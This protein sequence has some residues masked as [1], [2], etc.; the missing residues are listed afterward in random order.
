MIFL[1]GSLETRCGPASRQ[2]PR[3]FFLPW[4][5]KKVVSW[6]RRAGCGLAVPCVGSS[7]QRV[8]A[9]PPAALAW[10][11]VRLKVARMPG[12]PRA[13]LSAV[14]VCW[15]SSGCVLRLLVSL[16][17]E[18][19]MLISMPLGPPG[20][21]MKEG[22]ASVGN[23]LI[24]ELAFIITGVLCSCSRGTGFNLAGEPDRGSV[25]AYACG[26]ILSSFLCCCKDTMLQ[27]TTCPVIIYELESSLH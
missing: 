4:G 21:L 11:G 25:T 27:N 3:I 8:G 22:L 7:P 23:C 12:E 26:I 9:P 19:K 14:S 18:G 15:V 1:L 16:W 2:C 20:P 24:M 17:E 5:G 10:V 13:R 6:S